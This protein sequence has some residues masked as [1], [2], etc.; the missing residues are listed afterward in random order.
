MLASDI[1]RLLDGLDPPAVGSGQAIVRSV[2]HDLGAFVGW[3]ASAV[4]VLLLPAQQGPCPEVRLRHLDL[5]PSSA[6]TLRVAGADTTQILKVAVLRCRLEQPGLRLAFEGVA[7]ALCGRLQDDGALDLS[8]QIPSLERLFKAFREEAATTVVGLWAELVVLTEAR[9]VAAATDAWHQDPRDTFD[10][11]SAGRAIEVK[12]SRDVAREHWIS[13][14]QWRAS[15]HVRCELASL[16]V[17]PLADGVSITDLLDRG[18]TRLAGRPALQSKLTDVATRTLGRDFGRAG[19][20]RFDLDAAVA[21]LRFIPLEVVPH[22]TF[23][24]GVLDARWRASLEHIEWNATTDW[25]E[26]APARP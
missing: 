6:V 5:L 8:L 18:Q 4:A 13:L 11:R 10:F 20:D 9:D 22:G 1:A 24:S 26:L 14:D 19:S 3:E 21:S 12:G 2:G 16:V 23:E 7:A 25:T 15:E 17:A